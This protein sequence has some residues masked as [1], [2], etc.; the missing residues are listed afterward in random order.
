MNMYVKYLCFP[1]MA[2]CIGYI[3]PDLL[4]RRSPLVRL[5]DR[6]LVWIN[7][8]SLSIKELLHHPHV[9]W[10]T[11]NKAVAKIIEVGR[12]KINLYFY[13]HLIEPDDWHI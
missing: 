1:N 2:V 13:S 7:F 4:E 5:S 8:A 3:C 11:D 9:K 12:I 10:Y 6:P